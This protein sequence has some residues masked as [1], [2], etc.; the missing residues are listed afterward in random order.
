MP[1]ASRL[2]SATSWVVKIATFLSLALVAVLVVAVGALMLASLGLFTIPIPASVTHGLP[3]QAVLLAGGMVV[4][5]CAVVV[6]MTA[7][8]LVLVGRIVDSA[9]AGD[10][11]VIKNA[12][13]LNAIGGMLVAIQVVG[14]VTGI[15]VSAFPKPINHDLNFGFD[16]SLTGLFA[17]LLVFVLAQIFRHGAQMREELEGTV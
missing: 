8:I 9:R 14:L 1:Q 10:P 13:R 5:A 15:A 4:V 12:N 2:F 17:A 11:F 6:A 7:I 3:L 16:V